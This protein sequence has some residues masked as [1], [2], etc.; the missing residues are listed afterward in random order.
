M[1]KKRKITDIQ[2]N[3]KNI[4]RRIIYLDNELFIETD[5]TITNDLD[6]YIGKNL[7]KTL[8]DKI[9]QEELLLKAKKESIRF[10]SYRPRSQWEIENKL[11]NK[12]YNRDIINNTIDWLKEKKLIDDK[13]F[14]QMWIKDRINKKASGKLR[15]RKELY[16]KGIDREIIE[17]VINDF[18][19]QEIDELELAYQMIQKKKNSLML[20]NIQL[21]PQKIVSLLKNRGFSYHVVYH[22]YNEL[23]TE[24]DSDI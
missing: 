5:D 4:K 18:F 12:K 10:L 8:I 7:T 20:K 11:K 16:N 3:K 17:S 9:K 2:I 19:D 23:F 14:S 6:L 22:I 21:E 13:I 1:K 15:L 24:K